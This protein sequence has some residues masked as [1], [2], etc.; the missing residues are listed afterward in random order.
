MCIVAKNR[1]I[2]LRS[3]GAGIALGLVAWGA[4][5]LVFLSH[6]ELGIQP[7][8]ALWLGFLGLAIGAVGG[9]IYFGMKADR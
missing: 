9:L 2:W 3:L 6:K 7:A 1:S 8:S 4:F 5:Y